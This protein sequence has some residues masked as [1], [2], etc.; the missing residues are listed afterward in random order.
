MK[1]VETGGIRWAQETANNA[2]PAMNICESLVL[3]MEQGGVLHVWNASMKFV[4]DAQPPRRL[5][6]PS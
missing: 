1:V 3:S 6:L 4:V 2:I 5:A